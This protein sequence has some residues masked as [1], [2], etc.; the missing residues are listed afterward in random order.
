MNCVI[1]SWRFALFNCL[2]EPYVYLND[3]ARKFDL[4]FE[5]CIFMMFSIFITSLIIIN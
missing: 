2:N 4:S 3:D 5:F 1:H